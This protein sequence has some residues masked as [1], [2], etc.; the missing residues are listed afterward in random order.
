M[1]TKSGL[2]LGV[3]VLMVCH[4]ALLAQTLVKALHRL[5]EVQSQRFEQREPQA[6]FA[7]HES[8]TNQTLIYENTN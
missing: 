1:K 6:E 3:V 2:I 4:L 7:S 8:T 5:D